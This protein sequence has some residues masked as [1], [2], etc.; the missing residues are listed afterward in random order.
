MTITATSTLN[1][2]INYTW[3]PGPQFGPTI[4]ICPTTPT[5]YTVSVNSPSACPA[6]ATL[7]VSIATNCCPQA[8]AGLSLL[9]SVGGTYVNTSYSLNASVTLTANTSFQNSEVWI[10]PGVQIT[11]PTGTV[12]DLDHAH[13]YACGIFMWRGI[14]VQD[15]GSITTPAVQTRTSNSMIEDAEIAIEL[16]GITVTNTFP[17]PPVNIQ[18]IVFNRNF[19]GIKFS[20][21]DILLDSLAVGITGCVFTSRNMTFATY[22]LAIAWPSADMITG[23]ALRI[24]TNPTTGLI[25]PYDLQAFPT[26]NLKQ[27]YPGQAGHTGN[28]PGHIGIKIENIGDPFGKIPAAGI[29]IGITY[30]GPIINDFN[31]FDAIGT[32]IEVT[33][34]SLTTKNNVFQNMLSYSYPTSTG[35]YGGTGINHRINAIMNAR[36]S[37]KGGISTDDGNRFWDCITGINVVNVYETWAVFNLFRSTHNVMTANNTFQF[38][39]AGDTAI[40]AETNRFDFSVKECEFNNE[41][42]GIMFSTPGNP[43]PY[44]FGNVSGVGIYARALD[45]NRNYFGPEVL[46][47]TPY[48][49][50]GAP[51]TTEYFSDAIQ[52]N[53]P[54]PNGWYR[55]QIGLPSFINSNRIDRCF[56]G[57][58]INGT[59]DTPLSVV[60]NSIHIED[61][62]TTGIPGMLEFGWGISAREKVGDLSITGNTLEAQGSWAGTN[63]VSLVHCYWN[64]GAGPYISCNRVKNSNYGFHFENQNQ[65]TVWEK[66]YM[67]DNWA[68]MALTNSAVI[69]PQGNGSAGMAN[70]WMTTCSAWNFGQAQYQTYCDQ[71]NP[72]MSPLFFMSSP[73][74]VPTFNG[75][76]PSSNPA[77]STAPPF[78]SLFSASTQGECS[79]VN[80]YQ[81][82]PGWRAGSHAIT[83]I[84][85]AIIM[86]PELKVFP[87]PTKEYL[88]I[89]FPGSRQEINVNITDLTGKV[90]YSKT[91]INSG[92][93]ISMIHLSPS[94]YFLELS[95]TGITTVR[96]KIIITD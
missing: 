59:E 83:E 29:Q 51:N 60:A 36:L 27:P 20:N 74:F 52:I 6:S 47:S 19:I 10:T 30:P 68:G 77:Y 35:F 73:G 31:L 41:K 50:G 71:S 56:R 40:R 32:G 66:N 87:N 96:K 48:S 45:I 12:L 63:S 24:A 85:D 4:S 92:E 8:P 34:A 58:L 11:V 22:P 64:W 1:V 67:C 49:G 79:W 94:I 86:E 81:P 53:T 9:S 84:Q 44:D 69:G 91:N 14:Q 16:D 75:N 37:S 89:V 13:L 43:M 57:I 39:I 88:T 93:G 55:P 61:D 26:I 46:S 7:A 54:N 78:P 5:V 38:G 18:R 42:F 95:G 62:L 65:G 28:Q 2:P 70:V 17:K 82:V 33:D 23:P 25:P 15:G 76:F 80:Y 3:M 21:S 72:A 90:V